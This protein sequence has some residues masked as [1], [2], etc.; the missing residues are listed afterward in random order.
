MPDDIVLYKKLINEKLRKF[1]QSVG[2]GDNRLLRAMEYSLFSGGKL[3]RPLLSLS[4]CNLCNGDIKKALPLACAVEMIHT[5]SLVHDDLP[6][7]DNDVTRRGKPSNHIINGE[8]FAILAGDAL[9]SLA[10]E[11]I[12][13]KETTELLGTDVSIKAAN[14]LFKCCGASGMVDGQA[15]EFSLK[16]DMK[17]LVPDFSPMSSMDTLYLK[18]TGKLFG[19]ACALGCLAAGM[20]K[21]KVEAANRYGEDIGVVYQIIDDLKDNSYSTDF[22]FDDE[23]ARGFAVVAYKMIVNVMNTIK[24]NFCLDEKSFINIFGQELKTVLLDY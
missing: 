4:F 2:I 15:L 21:T 23:A 22:G 10:A 20:D 8:N 3:V 1:L 11:V 9:F 5:Y 16:K 13:D 17:G 14:I 6:C 19:A 24:N 7:M 12:T 18:K